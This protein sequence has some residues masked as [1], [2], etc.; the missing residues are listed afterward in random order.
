MMNEQ[1]IYLYGQIKTSQTGGQPYIE[2]FP[3]YTLLRL[4]IKYLSSKAIKVR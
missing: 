2:T 1:Q 3:D 4:S